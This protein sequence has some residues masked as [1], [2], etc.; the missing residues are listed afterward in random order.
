MM[1]NKNDKTGFNKKKFEKEHMGVNS[2]ILQWNK[3]EDVGYYFGLGK[4]I[5]LNERE[6]EKGHMTAE[7]Y[8]RLCYKLGKEEMDKYFPEYVEPTKGSPTK[9]DLEAQAISIMMTGNV[10]QL[11]E[12]RQTN[13]DVMKDWK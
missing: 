10:K 9:E 13:P 12:F 4:T 6:L 8:N 11:E 1:G 3:W 7:L 2:G 5:H